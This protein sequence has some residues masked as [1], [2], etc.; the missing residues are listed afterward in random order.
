MKILRWFLGV[1]VLVAAFAAFLYHDEPATTLTDATGKEL[2]SGVGAGAEVF[3][4]DAFDRARELMDAGA[5]AAAE[6]ELVRLLEETERDGEACILLSEVVRELERADE[7]ADYGLKA[8]ELLPGSADAH[9]VYAQAIGA[10]LMQ[11]GGGLAALARMAPRLKRMKEE[12]QRVI[13]LDPQDTEAR[14]ILAMTFLMLPGLMGG[15][16]DR[17]IELCREIEEIAPVDGKKLLAIALHQTGAKDDALALCRDALEEFPEER[18]FHVTIGGYHAEEQRFEEADAAYEAA[19]AGEKDEDYYLALYMQARMRVE[20]GF[21]AER[22]LALLAEFIDAEPQGE[23]V[24]SIASALWRKGAA[25]ELAGDDEE[26]RACYRESLRL[27]PG[28]EKAQEALDGLGRE[29][30]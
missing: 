3:A 15:D 30:S 9:L 14:T 28:F 27:D 22:A 4:G 2:T 12:C 10:Q 23:F 1:L 24:P 5:H 18:G 16:P 26:A 17:A 29:G 25:H 21:E 13:E 20:N 19:R 8:V 7:A 11:G 6:V